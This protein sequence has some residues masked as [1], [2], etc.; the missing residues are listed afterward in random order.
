MRFV[1]RL[2]RRAIFALLLF[3]LVL[4]AP[5]AYV[6]TMCRG[7][8][9]ASDYVPILPPEHH[10]AEARAFLTY[11]EWH[12]VHAYDD[13]GRVIATG[14][15]HDYAFLSGIAGFWT[16]LCALSEKSAAHGGFDTTTKQTIYTIG[17]SFTL[18]LALKA[19][20][21][22]T[23]GRIA[24]WLRGEDRSPL[25]DLSA[26]QAADYAEFLQQIPWYRW[27]FEREIDALEQANSGSLRDRERRFALGVEYATKAAYARVIESAVA[28]VG[29]D[30]LR[31][32]MIV[33]GADAATLGR[34]D[35]VEIIAERPEGIEIE[36]PRYRV[37]TRLLQKMAG[38]GADFVE[39]AGNDDIMLTAL[40][41]G[42]EPDA[43][44]SFR[45]QGYGDMRHLIA[46]PV[47]QL[48]QWLRANAGGPLK[49]EHIHDY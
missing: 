42:A 20:Y 5:V 7:E 31:L 1:W 2:L 44:F 25:D 40:S 10:R 22:E 48:A 34:L 18:E 37:L 32:R 30:A 49:L 11:P 46:L 36:T 13:Y 47:P 24:A 21:E 17:A 23:V 35:G 9:V 4:L 29:P 33:T 12:I 39:I 8:V 15:P 3:I 19:V 43:L 14:D 26:R 45:R 28:S 6:E 16:S 38:R 27:D 41:T